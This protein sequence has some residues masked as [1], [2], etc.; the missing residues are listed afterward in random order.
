MTLYYG[1]HQLRNSKTES[2]FA[3]F[4]LDRYGDRYVAFV[5]GIKV[6]DGSITIDFENGEYQFK[7]RAY[8]KVQRLFCDL[9]RLFYTLR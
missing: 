4:R 1:T 6:Y 3:N 2:A 5:N 8:S 7:L 9:Y